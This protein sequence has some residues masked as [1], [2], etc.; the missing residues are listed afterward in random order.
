MCNWMGERSISVLGGNISQSL[1]FGRR[2]KVAKYVRKRAIFRQTWAF[3]HKAH[4]NR[5]AYGEKPF[6]LWIPIISSALSA[7]CSSS[8]QPLAQVLH[9]KPPAIEKFHWFCS[10]QPLYISFTVYWILNSAQGDGNRSCYDCEKMTAE[11]LKLFTL[12]VLER[13]SQNSVVPGVA[14]MQFILNTSFS[15]HL[16]QFW[17]HFAI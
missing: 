15:Y 5:C 7:L 9:F 14:A 12:G 2:P 8:L 16:A 10:L 11:V 17:S 3:F 1:N 13:E 6:A 4:R